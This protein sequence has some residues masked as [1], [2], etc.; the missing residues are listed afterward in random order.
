M[1]NEMHIRSMS[2]EEL[3]ALLAEY[4]SGV[5][6]KYDPRCEADLNDDR[7][8]P[9]ERCRECALAWLKAPHIPKEVTT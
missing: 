7:L 4:E 2:S 9:I 5:I 3:A 8:I 6:C 1:T